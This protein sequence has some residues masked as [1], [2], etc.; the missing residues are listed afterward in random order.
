MEGGVGV[1]VV[2]G[3]R[4]IVFVAMQEIRAGVGKNIYHQTRVE[5]RRELWDEVLY[6]A[7][8]HFHCETWGDKVFPLP[9]SA[10]RSHKT[11]MQAVRNVCDVCR[12]TDHGALTILR[13]QTGQFLPAGSSNLTAKFINVGGYF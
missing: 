1:G 13:C 9:R 4:V 10:M 5:W 8:R 6:C 12:T 11:T 2:V 3:G 7:V